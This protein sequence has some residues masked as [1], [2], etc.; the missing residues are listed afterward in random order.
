M[1]MLGTHITYHSMVITARFEYGGSDQHR[2][3]FAFPHL[4][5]KGSDENRRFS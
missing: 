3:I 4:V 5:E 2:K 1:P